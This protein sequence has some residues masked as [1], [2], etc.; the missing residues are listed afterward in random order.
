M[1]AFV[2]SQDHFK[3][4]GIFAARQ[5]GGYGS[6]R[7]TVNPKYV[8]GL[9]EDVL[10]LRNSELAE[11]YANIL[12]N[13]NVRSCQARYPQD[14]FSGLPGEGGKPDS[15]TILNQEYA[16]QGSLRL[17]A[18]SIL[19][20][21][22][23]LEYQSCETEDYRATLAW[24]LLNHIRKEAWRQ[25]PGYEDA[26]WDYITPERRAAWRAEDEAERKGKAEA[27]A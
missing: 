16:M 14:T 4:L 26:P 25:L 18:V 22:D 23:C 17:P 15:I 21:C 24:E 3:V 19:K 5:I 20:M 13:E 1:S 8:D 6:G 2:C 11:A 10:T 9:P 7:L 27:I 12:Y